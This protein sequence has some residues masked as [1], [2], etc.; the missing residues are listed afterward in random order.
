MEG[1]GA[2]DEGNQNAGNSLDLVV[3]C[4]AISDQSWW[5]YAAMA[6]SLHEL[7]RSLSAWAEG[8][9]C[10][11]WLLPNA[12]G[13]RSAEASHLCQ[14][15]GSSEFQELVAGAMIGDGSE[16]ACPMSGLRAVELAASGG[17]PDVTFVEHIKL[18]A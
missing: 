14:V 4:Q 1:R 9:P 18:V 10:H 15:H 2:D 8:C 16:F 12:S 3:I 13:H 17:R 7:A 5:A 11:E 6:L